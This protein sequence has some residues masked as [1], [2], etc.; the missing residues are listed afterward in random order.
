MTASPANPTK[1]RGETILSVDNLVKHFP[2]TQGVLFQRQIGA[3]KAVDGV[4]FELRRGETLGVVGESGCGKSTLARLLMRL[5]TPT[6]GRATL[7][8]KD[9]FKASGGELRRLRRNMQM[10]MQDPY[11]S[12]NPRMTVGDI[13]GEPFE[14]HPDAAPKGS[15][16]KRVQEL[17]DLVGLNPEHI[18]RYPHQFS[19]GQRQRIG[20]ARALALKPEVIV[21]DEPVSALDVSIQAQVINLLKQLQGE[22]GLS[23]IFIAHDLSVVRHIADRVAVMYLGR[24]VEIGTED[25]IYERATHP[26]TQALL[27]A[28]PVP[29]PEARDQRNMIRLVGD[30][31][32]PADPP[33]GCHFRTRCWKAQDICAVEDPATVPRAADPHP[34]A[35]HFAELRPTP[36]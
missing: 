36:A 11:T 21:C 18:N 27:S 20:I 32:S 14:I 29:D 16:A 7:E 24:I 26:Y 6:S 4:S 9:L 31:P 33:S 2:I 1:V 23:Y 13:I 15:K 8:G 17:L 12:L 22:L 30:V 35:C 5:E 34:S 28:V 19:G 25:E 10:V 3:V